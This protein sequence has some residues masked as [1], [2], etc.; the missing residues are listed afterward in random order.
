MGSMSMLI[1]APHGS[2]GHGG[3]PHDITD[4]MIGGSESRPGIAASRG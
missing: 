3:G 2:H 1:P 4:P